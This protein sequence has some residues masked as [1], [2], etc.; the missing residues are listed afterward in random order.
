MAMAL[1]EL[2]RF[3]EASQWQRNAIDMA[4]KSGRLDVVRRLAANLGQYE[5]R[6]PCRVPWA[7]DD[8]I[9]HPSPMP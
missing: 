8:P 6:R 3:D 7:D 5:I 4:S 1:A 9:H 2:G